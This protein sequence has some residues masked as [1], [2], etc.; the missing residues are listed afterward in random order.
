MAIRRITDVSR[1]PNRASGIYFREVDLTVASNAVGGFSAALIGLTEK[2]PAFEISNSTTYED[3]AFRLGE[4]N[5]RYPSSYF[6]RQYLEQGRNFKEIRVLGL[7]GYTDTVGYAVALDIAGSSPAVPGVSALALAPNSLM[8]VLKKRNTLTTGRP[9]VTSVSIEAVTYVDPV[10]NVSVTDCTDY[11]F[12]VRILYADST[13]ELITTSLRP[14]SN[15]YIVKKFGTNPLDKP[16]IRTNIASLW[17]DFII[18]STKSRPSLSAPLSYYLPGSTVAQN[19]LPIMEG[20]VAFG[21]TTTLQNAPVTNVIVNVAYTTVE[22]QGDVTS[23][24]VNGDYIQITNVTGTGNIEIVNNIWIVNSVA[25]VSGNT[26]FRINNPTDNTPLIIPGPITFSNVNSP[27][28]A[29]YVNPT[30]EREVLDFADITY[31]TPITPWF[32]SDGDVNGDFKRLF[33]FWSISDGRIASSEIKIEIRNIDPAGNNGL[34]SFDVIVR[35]WSDREDVEQ[36]TLELFTNLTMTPANDNY[37]LRRIGDGED[38]AL[39]SRFIFVE[40]NLDEEIIGTSLPWGVLGFPN[41]TGSKFGDLQW[42]LEYNKNQP[43]QKQSLGL[44]NNSINTFKPVAPDV[45]AFKNSNGLTIG[46]GF[47][48]NPNNNTT[49]ATLNAAVFQFANQNIY[50][51]IQSQPITTTEKKRRSKFVVD[52]YGGF[53]GFNV[54][55]ERTWGNVTSKDYEALTMAV[56]L[57]RDKESFD[58]DFTVL[59]TPDMFLDTHAAACEYV[60]DMVTERQ[61]CLYLPDLSYDETADTFVAVDLVGASSMKS[62]AVAVYFPWLQIEDPIN[63][64]NKWVPPSILALG[65]ITYCAN[66]EQVWQPPGGAIRT[67]TNNLVRSRRRLKSNDREQ[68]RAANINGITSFPSSGYEITEVRTTQEYDSALSYIHNRLL[69]CYAKKTLNQLLRPLLFQLNGEVTRDAFLMTVRPV[70]DRIKKLNGVEEYK[71]EVIDRPEL[72]DRTTLYGSITIVPL[73]PVERIIIDFVLQDSALS[74]NQ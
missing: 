61:D 64:V 67:V 57:L 13:T 59:V 63:R 7:E 31:Q 9:A 17:V 74:F 34:G 60:L 43:I 3:R 58:S 32:V 65:T 5:P 16:I 18:P 49:F 55:S 70:F 37:I 42:T 2:G 33:R 10:T 41:V 72:N 4:L 66:N 26:Q 12:G 6:A 35:K 15:D 51:N 48:L 38:F 14:E 62:N 23:W 52:F 68:L 27:I 36:V 19:Y 69:L 8:V 73:Y 20:N 54:Y 29:E 53:D 50:T 40:M 24:L 56:E 30:W 46:K 25:L 71:V 44:S 45:L 39:R 11:L 47:H 1:I 28:G 21:T 22:L